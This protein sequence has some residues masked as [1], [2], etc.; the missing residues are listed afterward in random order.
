MITLCGQYVGCRWHE[1]FISINSDASNKRVVMR[2]MPD[3]LLL[4]KES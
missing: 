4:T 3:T 2:K 1:N